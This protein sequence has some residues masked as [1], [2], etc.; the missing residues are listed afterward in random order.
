MTIK[1]SISKLLLFMCCACHASLYSQGTNTSINLTADA[2]R[3]FS[4]PFTDTIIAQ[5][6]VTGDVKGS[7][8]GDDS[9]VLI[10]AVNNNLDEQHLNNYAESIWD[11]PSY[12]PNEIILSIKTNTRRNC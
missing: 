6:G 11:L 8:V 12:F 5:A 9:T 7:I 3:T 4:S 1:Q 10:D 2:I